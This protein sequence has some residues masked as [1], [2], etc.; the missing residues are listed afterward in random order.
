MKNFKKHISFV[1]LLCVGF[2]LVPSISYACAKKRRTQN[3]ILLKRKSKYK[4]ICKDKSC[5]KC[6]DGHDC[7]DDCN[8][9]SCRCSTSS[10]FVSLPIPIDLKVTDPFAETKSKNSVLNKPIILQATRLFGNRLK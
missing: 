7:G 2:F 1:I 10:S 4:E 6:K 5:K 9:S 8:H 3:K